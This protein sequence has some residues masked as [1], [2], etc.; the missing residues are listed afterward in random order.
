MPLWQSQ[1]IAHMKKYYLFAG[2][3]LL[4]ASPSFAQ[5]KI[6]APGAPDGSAMLE[7]TSGAANN[8][9]LLLPRMT[10]VQRNA[11]SAPATGLMIY[12]TT[13]NQVQVNTGTP[14]AP[15]WV[16]ATAANSGWDLVGNNGTNPATNFIGTTDNQPLTIRTNNTEKVRVTAT[17]NVGIGTTIPAASLHVD[18]GGIRVSNGPVALTSPAIQVINDG[19]GNGNNDNIVI[20]SFGANT[21]PSIGT[22]SSRGTF[23]AP[24]NSQAGDNIGNFFFN[25]RVNGSV[26]NST[27]IRGVYLGDGTTN[28]SRLNLHTSNTLAMT[29][30]SNQNVG[31][32]TADPQQTLHVAGTA[33]ITGSSGTATTITGRNATGD[34]SNVAIG[35]GLALTGG[36]LSATAATDNTDWNLTGNAGTSPATNFIGTSDAQPLAIRTNNIEQVRVT[37]AGNVG[38]NNTNPLSPL[39]FASVLEP[40]ITLW[41]GGSTTNHYGIG[42]SSNQLNY[43]VNPGATH[44]FY[45]GGTNGDGTELM[46]IQSDGDVGIGTTTPAQ[47]LHVQGT[48][49]I[50]NA[51]GTPSTITGR[52]AAGDVGN[53]TLGSG[54]SLTGGVLNTT[55]DN[56]DWN[57]TGNA[58]TSPATNFIG[59]SDN[60]ALAIRTDNIE[61]VRVTAAGNVGIGTTSPTQKL[62][63][64]DTSDASVLITAAAGKQMRVLFGSTNHG[65]MRNLTSS[66]GNVN[67]VAL[68]TSSGV[69]LG[70]L[71]LA[72]NSSVTGSD[73][74]PL[75]QFVLKNSG[76]VGIGTN[77]PA[78][79]LHVQG[80]ARI[81][82]AVG[83]PT[84]I[85]GR[86]A[87]GDVGNVAIG[88]GLAL[89]AGTLSVT[90]G[91]NDWDLT[92][93][94]GTNPSTNF[95][96]TSDA[97]PLV[98]RTDNTEQVRVTAAGNVGIGT[99]A[100]TQTL[101]V[102]GTAR[103]RNAV[104]TPTTIAGRNNNGD[105]GAVTLGSGLSLT[106]G[107]LNTTADN[108]DW[109]LTGNTG[110]NP[111]TNFIGTGDAQPLVIR[112]NNTEQ[113]RVTAAGNVGINNTNPLSPLSFESAAGSKISFFSSGTTNQYGIGLTTNQLNYHVTPGSAHAFFTGGINGDGTELMRIQGNG[114]VGIGTTAPARNL[115][116][117]GNARIVDAIGTPTTITGRNAV[118]DVGNVTVGSGLALTAGVLTATP[119]AD[120]T[121][122]NITGNTGT[123]PATN[124]IGTGDAQPL[125]IRTSNIEQ[126]RVTA[127]G[128]VGIGTQNPSSKLNVNGGSLNVSN[129]A[130]I[131]SSALKVINDGGG[132][133]VV[134]DVDIYSYGAA[135]SPAMSMWT[136]R[137]TAAAPL[138]SQ[139]NDDAG[140]F[141]FGTQVNG[142]P[143]ELNRI[144]SIYLGDGTTLKSRLTFYASGAPANAPTLTIDSSGYVGIGIVN[145]TAKLSVN[146]TA[147]NATGTWGIFSDARVKTVDGEYEDGLATVMKIHPVKFHYNA[148]APFK[149]TEQQIGII[150]QE[151]EQIAPYMVSK[152]E[153]DG[154][155]DLRQYN[156]QALPYMLVNSI[157]EQQAQIETFKVQIETFK[158]QIEALKAKNEQ[159]E[160]ANKVTAQLMERVKQMEQMMGIK[161]IEGTSKVAGK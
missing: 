145:P 44:T 46:R 27:V 59:T 125:A 127:A 144:Q 83:T 80:T 131:S 29:I 104:G 93:N 129:T 112:T 5:T 146:G 42:V 159:L 147:N 54:L 113:V 28:K 25:S 105:V 106:A 16:I 32:G 66:G 114:N 73:S 160:T 82:T 65:V 68:Y 89:T 67:D 43:H 103:I 88:T 102:V 72:A 75:E 100:P 30:D 101:D 21:Q 36:T 74:L 60:Q 8:K 94:A 154:F 78:Q 124:F 24:Q 122:W 135:T 79:K 1:K 109:N 152:I 117:E 148:N 126:V 48:A 15:V 6:G 153:A 50:V 156:N 17:G 63:V 141:R 86:N 49:R 10:T 136:A 142:V 52:N 143:R 123:N 56:A 23:S 133:D 55:A 38:I 58:G 134:D 4:A 85:T 13:A 90:G 108:A 51:T 120:N 71:H 20:N 14:A 57:L 95:I 84:T 61:K 119:A 96:G 2:L 22:Q 31:L 11:I 155:T 116:V 151:M 132:S 19:G 140:I 130:P 118:G 3:V 62:Q 99:T 110:T 111:A 121:D 76:N 77:T 39:S 33:R 161:E 35:S 97:Q 26:A 138:N 18:T 53:V 70:D 41:N 40:K 69:G 9:G 137:G 37:A 12:N 45:T 7:V 47:T 98:I 150:A 107:V 128:D 92:G 158:V 81:S 64:T 34:V 139:V 149:S 115:H 157:Q 91:T 87:A